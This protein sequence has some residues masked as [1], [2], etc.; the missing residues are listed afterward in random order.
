VKPLEVVGGDAMICKAERYCATFCCMLVFL[1]AFITSPQAIASSKFPHVD[2]N[3][4]YI[5]EAMRRDTLGME[6]PIAAFALVFEALPS[7]VKIY[8]TENYFYFRFIYNGVPYA[9][10]IRFDPRTRDEGKVEF[11]FYKELTGW[12]FQLDKSSVLLLG[13][14]HGVVVEKIRTLAY[15]VT[16]RD[17]KVDFILNDLST[18]VPPTGAVGPDEKFLGPIFDESAI[19]FLLT[20]NSTTKAFYYILDETSPIPDELYALDS[21][22]RI[23]V[24]RRTGFAFYRDHHLDRKILIGV[25]E[26]NSKTNSY[27]D[28][29]FDQLPEN[30]VQG[31]DLRSAIEAADPSVLGKIDRL[32][33]YLDN[34]GRYLIHPYVMYKDG[35]DLYP[36]HKCASNAVA[37]PHNYY[38][39]HCFVN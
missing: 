16:F 12:Y 4:A 20:Y 26:I 25:Y 28:G 34:S 10:D 8:P 29:P 33:N 2:T 1:S 5:E 32:G 24:G 39:Y 17:K 23:L 9:G 27:F 38:Y 22:D 11:G 19:R 35:A 21:T 3:Q 30:F 37:I 15:R 18:F 36:I 7:E 14:S 31:D 6:D 13:A